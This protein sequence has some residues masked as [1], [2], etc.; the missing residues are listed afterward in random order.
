M[1]SRIRVKPRFWVFLMAL[2]LIVFTPLYIILDSHSHRLAETYA[3]LS[4]TRDQLKAQA[5]GL[6]ADLMYLKSER[7]VEQYARAHGMIMPG[8]VQY[9][10]GGE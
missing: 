5:D 2:F 7:G 6:R 1:M 3:Q 4:A 8:E 9:V 10:A